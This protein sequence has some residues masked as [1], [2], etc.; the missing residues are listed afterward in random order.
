MSEIDFEELKAWLRYGDIKRLAK[1]HGISGP[2]ASRIITRK[3]KKVK[4]E[5]LKDVIETA[6]HNKNEVLSLYD[7]FKKIQV[8]QT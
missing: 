1:K 7:S 2:H 3:T 4:M 8:P 6:I 5:F